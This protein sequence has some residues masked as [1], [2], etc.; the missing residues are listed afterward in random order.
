MLAPIIRQAL[1]EAQRRVEQRQREI[2]RERRLEQLDLVL[3]QA[4]TLTELL[5]LC[6]RWSAMQD[7]K[8]RR[9]PSTDIVCRKQK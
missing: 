7:E 6:W 8:V 4:R 5:P 9:D 2:E 3:A 1:A